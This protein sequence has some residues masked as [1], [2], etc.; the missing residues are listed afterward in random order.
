[1]KAWYSFSVAG[2]GAQDA[3][4]S[5]IAV[6]LNAAGVEDIKIAYLED[7]ANSLNAGILVKVDRDSVDKFVDAMQPYTL[8]QL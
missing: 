5:K 4:V 2:D 7:M 8:V 3:F 1:M 6:A